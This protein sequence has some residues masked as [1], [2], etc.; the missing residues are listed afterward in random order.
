M[1]VFHQHSESDTRKQ[2][3][4][5]I[6]NLKLAFFLNFGF[7][8]I[9]FF[10]GLFTNSTAILADAVH[11]LG[12]SF[13]LAQAWYF[14][15]LSKKKE[16]SKYTYGYRRFTLLG[17]VISALLLLASSFYVLN[18]AVPRV[19]NPEHSNAQGMVLLA[20]FGVVVNGVAMWRLGKGSGAN[21]RI[22]ALHFLED[23]LGWTAVL[24][25]AIILLFKDVH[26]L[27]PILAILITLYIL[28][29]VVKQLKNIIPVFMQAAPASAD[30]SK[31]KKKLES[32]ENIDSLHHLH[33][34]SLD[35]EHT[36]L[37]V[38]LVVKKFLNPAEYSVLKKQV[39]E[40]LEQLDIYH[41]TIE[42]EW[43]EDICGNKDH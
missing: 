26:I 6:K 40:A 34:W 13:A 25:V 29:N 28:V 42:I 20:V 16:T 18:E 35:A 24:L 15:S 21:I 2:H 39:R 37:T 30:V 17:A 36:I 32:F 4:T 12:D 33:L 23:V 3:Q 9:E 14:E 22:V 38:H 8:I 11:D 27:D 1:T 5:A 10:G 43:P 7:T 41:T 19:L 31:I